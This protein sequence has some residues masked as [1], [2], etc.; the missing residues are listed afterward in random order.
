MTPTVSEAERDITNSIHQI[1]VRLGKHLPAF[2]VDLVE[3]AREA[4]LRAGHA[5]QGSDVPIDVSHYHGL[6]PTA[7]A[8]DSHGYFAINAKVIHNLKNAKAITAPS[9]W[10]ADVLRRDMHVNPHI[11]GWGVDTDE[12]TPA[13]EPSDYVLWNKARVDPVCDPASMLKLAARAPQTR[14]LTTFGEGTPNVRTVGRQ[15]YETMKQMVRKASVYLSTNVETFGIGTLE[16]MAAGVP[17]LG[18]RLPNTDHLI[19]HGVTGFLAEEGDIEGLYLGL[20]YCQ[21]HRKTLGANAREAAKAYSWER[22]A[23]QFAALYRSILEPHQGVK[24]SVILPCHNY[25]RYLP[26]ALDSVLAQNAD[27]DIEVIVVCDRCT[28]DSE[29]VARSYADRGVFVLVADNGNL[30]ATRNEGIE[31]ASGEYICCLDSDDAI[32]SPDF[33][34]TLANALDAD[35]TLGIAFTG[36]QVMDSEGKLGHL[37]AWPRGYDFNKQAAHNNQVPSCCLFRKEAWRRAGGFRPYFVYAQDAEFWTTVGAIGYGATQV[38]EAGWFHYR[39]HNQSQSQVHRN[40]SIPEPDW[41]EWHPWTKDGARPLA[42]DGNPPYG[43]WPVRFYL[44]PE[45]SVIIPVGKGHEQAVKDAL[46]SV[47]GQT[48]RKWE[49]IVVNDTHSDLHL[50]DG[51]PWVKVINPFEPTIINRFNKKTEYEDFHL[52][53]GAARNLGAKQ[54]HAPFV[55]FLDAD[56]MLKPRFLE[57]TLQAYKQHGRYAYTDWLTEEQQT[58]FAVHTT[59]EYTFR[60]VWERPSIHPVTTLLPRLWFEAVGGFDEQM[61][62]FEDVDFFMKMLVHGY[63]GVRVPEPLLVYHLRSG[64][65]RTAGEAIKDQF[66]VLLTKRYGAYMEGRTMCNC[67]EPPKGKPRVPPS[68]DNLTEYR[69]TYG[70]MV[71]V[72][73]TSED[74]PLGAVTFLG[75]A[76]RVNYGRR[77][78]NEVFYVWEKDVTHSEGIFTVLND[79]VPEAV[80]TVVPPAPQSVVIPPAKPAVTPAIT[81]IDDE[82][83]AEVPAEP[84]PEA[85]VLVSSAKKI[86]KSGKAAK[87]SK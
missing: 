13:P 62:A 67:V 73:L 82:E 87:S 6:Y 27:F 37:N 52:G 60:A 71:K 40:G 23:E 24:V 74:A 66:K 43:S 55:V 75:P 64:F 4:D 45:V 80:P 38:T 76:T 81:P 14:F 63:C 44:K 53:A 15:P 19:E 21:K 8:M 49:C 18:Y 65:R 51:F 69:A 11:I 59:P 22:L 16:A 79:Y 36:I 72:Q 34:Q 35:R 17:V 1:V 29:A 33:L 7:D 3:N 61:T 12:W 42:A 86:A 2:G 26:M 41:L 56:D 50:E 32:G 77:V 9:E 46:H 70:E 78:R 25:A 5:G 48:F 57:T 68:P 83:T 85:E 30:S 31:R 54:S 58:N 47:E 10:I 84:Q 20:L 39:L 28:D